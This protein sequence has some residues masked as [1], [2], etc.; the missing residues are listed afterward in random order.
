MAGKSPVLTGMRVEGMPDAAQ[1][2]MV[3]D[4]E[5]ANT[6][7]ISFADINNAITANLGSSYINDYPNTGR[8][9]RVIVQADDRARLQIDDVMKINV[10]NAS[11]GMVPLSSFAI[12]QWQKGAPQIV[13]YNGYPTVRISGAPAPGQSSGAAIAE[14]ERL[15]SQL[16]EGFGFEWS[17]QSAEEI[18]S[19]SQAPILFSLSILFVF[20]LLAGL[21]E[22]WSIPL[23]VMLVVPLGVIGAV[24]AVMLR[25]MPN[26]IYFK[27]GLIAIIGLSAKNAI[28][29]VE[30]AEMAHRGGRDALEA[31]LEAARVRLRPILMTSIAFIA[32]VF[33][34][35]VASGAGA[36]SRIAIG[37]AVFGGMLTATLLAI[38]YVPMF[39]IVV[40]RLFRREAPMNSAEEI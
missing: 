5:K 8:M 25:D 15:A 40:A 38:F 12:A 21:Y 34:L 22:S 32:G 27:V 20:L 30:F 26:D 9:Q 19:G 13:G 37:T 33:P 6:F 14:M 10:R 36:Q 7:G 2:L 4:R 18:T 17:G 3:I 24:A 28:L 29:I 23:A 39:F 16:P 31:V 35:V 11:G 1:V